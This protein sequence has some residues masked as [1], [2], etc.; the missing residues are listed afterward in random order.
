[1]LDV[2]QSPCLHSSV[3]QIIS[4]LAF[5]LQFSLPRMDSASGGIP[6]HTILHILFYTYYSV[7]LALLCQLSGLLC[8]AL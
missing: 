1:M 2:A 5:L 7:S 4:L 8:S 6:T 3:S